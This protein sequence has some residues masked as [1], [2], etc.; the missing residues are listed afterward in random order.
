MEI[1]DFLRKQARNIGDHILVPGQRKVKLTIDHAKNLPPGAHPE[2]TQAH[3]SI[4]DIAQEEWL[5]NLKA[6]MPD[7]RLIVEEDT[8]SVSTFPI[9]SRHCYIGDLLD[10]TSQYGQG[11][12]NFGLSMAYA[13]DD[14][15]MHSVIYLPTHNWFFQASTG[16]GAYMNHGETR[17]PSSEPKEG[18]TII[19]NSK[20]SE[21]VEQRLKDKGFNV[22]R[23]HCSVYGLALLA[24]GKAKAYIAQNTTTWDVA[25]FSHFIETAGGSVTDFNLN[26]IPFT[27]IKRVDDYIASN[28]HAYSQRLMEI[29]RP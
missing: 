5:T 25:P 8:P 3:C 13:L 7:A 22:E 15:I 12:P 23:P 14:E 1:V 9:E 4:D 11:S 20:M 27:R 2:V 6:F 21:Q 18:D 10:G 19:L 24:Q 28:C 16:V 29:I 17:L 26:Q